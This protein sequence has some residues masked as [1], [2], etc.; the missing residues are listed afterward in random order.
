MISRQASSRATA[1]TPSRQPAACRQR[2]RSADSSRSRWLAC[3][4]RADSSGLDAAEAPC[5][6]AAARELFEETGACLASL[7]PVAESGRV[8]HWGVSLAPAA[9][10]QSGPP[11][12]AVS[13][14]H[15]K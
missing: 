1:F 14:D 2:S 12:G 4:L 8:V 3:A 11:L 6:A 7:G 15:I 9:T 13:S 10:F 5:V